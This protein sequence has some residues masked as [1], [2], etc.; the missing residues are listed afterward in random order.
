MQVW[1]PFP[2]QE[3]LLRSS[4]F[5]ILFGG[6]AGG[7]KSQA[8]VAGGA[9]FIDRP[10][11]RGVLGRRTVPELEALDGLVDVSRKF[12]AP[13]GG[14]Y[15]AQKRQ[16]RFPKGARINLITCENEKDRF[17][18][19]GWQWQYLGLDELTT[20][21]EKI[22]L[23]L[24]ARIRTTAKIPVMVR[25]TSNPGGPGHEWVLKRWAPWLYRPNVRVEEYDGPYAKSG[26]V[27]FFQRDP[28]TGKESIVPPGTPKSFPRTFIASKLE[29]NPILAATDYG[30]RL[31]QLDVLTRRQLREGDWMVRAEPGM[32]FDRRWVTMIDEPPE[33]PFA[34]V[35]YWDRAGSDD[36]EARNPDRS[37]GVRMSLL[38]DG[39]MVVE[40]VERFAKGPAET[41]RRIC[42]R[43]RRDVL[44][45]QLR[46]QVIEQD[47]GNAGKVEVAVYEQ[48]FAELTERD[49]PTDRGFSLGIST[50]AVRPTG[51]KVDRFRPF[52]AHAEK[53]RIKVVRGTWNDAW[54][55]ELEGFPAGHDDQADGT[56]G[57][58]AELA[59][60]AAGGGAWFARAMQ[61]VKRERE[62][63]RQG[64]NGGR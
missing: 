8:L 21:L 5:E 7:G 37:A 34:R 58:Y 30:D 57:A 48:L 33:N 10:S 42:E 61:Q 1:R 41:Q 31:D 4:C 29:D 39:D 24:L 6:A 17:N 52:S 64:A 11:F 15:V 18:Y 32:L 47:P 53:G 40:H 28:S 9:R 38:D 59:E 25:C 43:A 3:A 54:F 13:L 14:Q 50:K 60:Y 55:D 45:V 2:R 51:S 46:E 44:E 63:E 19:S 49:D 26:E 12:Y 27:L 16:W 23:F 36:L 20:W 35:R 62:E 56:S 22:Y